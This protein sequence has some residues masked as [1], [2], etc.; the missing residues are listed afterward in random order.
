LRHIGFSPVAAYNAAARPLCKRPE[1]PGEDR[2]IA[3]QLT[4]LVGALFAGAAVY[5]SVAEHP[6]REQLDDRAQ[7]VQWKPAYKRGFVMQASLAVLGF[8]L[9][10]WAWW[11]TDNWPWLAGAALL[12]LNWPFTLFVIMPTNKRLMAT[13]PAAAGPETRTLMRRWGMLHACRTAFG[14]AATAV[15]LWASLA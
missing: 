3:G 6:A 4:L 13:D 8:L 15:F 10:V 5:V 7:L 1:V 14:T 12:I 2:M 9:G 11:Q